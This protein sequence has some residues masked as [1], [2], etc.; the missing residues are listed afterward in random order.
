MTRPKGIGDG[1]LVISSFD[2]E[3]LLRLMLEDQTASQDLAHEIER[4][5]EVR[6]EDIPPDVVTMNST[7]RVTDLES[8]AS[9]VYTIVFPSDADY[10]KRRISIMSP[11]GTALIGYRV[12]DLVE[13]RSPRGPQ[14]VRIDEI[15]YQPEASGDFHL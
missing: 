13:W 2:K 3:R 6:P 7:V 14:R 8:G 12:G 15:I 4:G 11:L 5:S 9:G 10:E 1:D